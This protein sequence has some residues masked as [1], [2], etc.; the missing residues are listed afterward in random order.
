MLRFYAWFKEQ[1]DERVEENHR[2]R[3]CTI[4]FYLSDGNIHISVFLFNT[5]FCLKM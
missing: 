1:V 4:Y 2:H 5:C 3:R